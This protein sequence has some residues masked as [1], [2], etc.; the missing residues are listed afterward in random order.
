VFAGGDVLTGPATVIEAIAAGQRAASSIKRY[1][2][3][4]ELSPLVERNGYEP[5]T[6]P[7]TPPTEAETQEKARVMI[8]EIPTAHK[9]TSFKETVLPYSPE[10]A[11]DEAGRCLRC[12]LEAGE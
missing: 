12:D 5:M 7:S 2:R 8:N 10:E 1:L 6:I 11:R 3:G 9:K 4:E